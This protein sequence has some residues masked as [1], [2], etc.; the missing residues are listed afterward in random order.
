MR[1]ARR[2]G[3]PRA[4]RARTAGVHTGVLAVCARLRRGLVLF[5][6]VRARTVECTT[7]G[8]GSELSGFWGHWNG[9]HSDSAI[10]RFGCDF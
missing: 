1:H 3:A 5:N 9:S 8:Q 6:Q 2:A 10:L 4:E 7:L